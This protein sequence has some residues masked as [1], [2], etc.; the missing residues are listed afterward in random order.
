M[1]DTKE[2][3]QLKE[4]LRIWEDELRKMIRDI[5]K[6]PDQTAK[7]V[8]FIEESTERLKKEFK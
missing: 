4:A 6:K 5:H 2:S 3:V 1:E 8:H 7:L